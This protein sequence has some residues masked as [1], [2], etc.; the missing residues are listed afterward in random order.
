MLHEPWKSRLIR[1]ALLR[2]GKG[3]ELGLGGQQALPD[4]FFQ[5][6]GP[7]LGGIDVDLVAEQFGGQ[8]HVLALASDGQGELVRLHFHVDFLVFLVDADARQFR[9]GQDPL[10]GRT[11][12]GAPPRFPL[13]G[14]SPHP[15]AKPR[16][17]P[18]R[19]PLARPPLWQG[20]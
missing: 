15:R 8:P 3:G 10:S 11:D 19:K 12:Q 9:P 6:E 7:V 2:C 18:L 14:Q 20:K 4:L 13:G 1:F 5:R 16:S 17:L